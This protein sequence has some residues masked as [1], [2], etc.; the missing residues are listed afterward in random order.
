MAHFP[1]LLCQFIYFYFLA[2]VIIIDQKFLKAKKVSVCIV[3]IKQPKKIL[4]ILPYA[5]TYMLVKWP[6]D[7]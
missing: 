6:R 2:H 4:Y 5:L 7:F 3:W 1:A